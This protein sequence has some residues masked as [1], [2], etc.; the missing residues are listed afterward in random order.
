MPPDAEGR[1]EELVA[2]YGNLIRRSIR[3]VGGK[4]VLS[5]AEDIEQEVKLSL[6]RRLQREQNIDYPASYVYRAAVRETVRV[7]RRELSRRG[8]PIEA[9]QLEAASEN[10]NPER[11]YLNDLQR[12]DVDH[13]LG[14][15][16]AERRHAVR[17]YIEGGSVSELMEAQGWSYQRARNLLARGMADLRRLLGGKP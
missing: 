11:L 6:W 9:V 15:L 7:V 1:L 5:V 12:Q 8:E 14:L 2:L 16:S 10:S 4:A 17:A 13:A 3:R